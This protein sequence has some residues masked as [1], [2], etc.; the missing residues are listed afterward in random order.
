MKIFSNL[1]KKHGLERWTLRVFLSFF[2][3]VVLKFHTLICKKIFTDKNCS[4]ILNLARTK[5]E[6]CSRS[7]GNQKKTV[8]VVSFL[9]NLRLSRDKLQHIKVL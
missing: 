6:D 5:I 8:S 7:Q 3:S 1:K 9:Y 2:I 4:E